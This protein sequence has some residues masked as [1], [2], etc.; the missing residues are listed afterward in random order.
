VPAADARHILHRRPRPHIIPYR[1]PPAQ[2]FGPRV[3]CQVSTI[4]MSSD[5]ALLTT[6][7]PSLSSLKTDAYLRLPNVWVSFAVLEIFQYSGRSLYRQP[8]LSSS[9][10]AR[11]EQPGV[12]LQGEI[13]GLASPDSKYAYCLRMAICLT[14]R[15]KAEV[16]NKMTPAKAT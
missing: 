10:I 8:I 15:S 1:P 4:L 14:R 12:R 6:I 13:A 3:M 16:T 9:H 2:Y 7:N 11:I 5:E